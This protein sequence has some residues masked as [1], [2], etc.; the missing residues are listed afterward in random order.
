MKKLLVILCIAATSLYSCGT[1]TDDHAHEG[2]GAHTHADGTQ[3][4]DHADT[5]ATAQEE[6]VVGADS[7]SPAQADSTANKPHN[8]GPGGHSH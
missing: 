5:S 2:E 6:F 8:H 1:Q 4:A 3:H 7:L